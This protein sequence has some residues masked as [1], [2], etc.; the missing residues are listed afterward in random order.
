MYSYLI[1][2]DFHMLKVSRTVG[3]GPA[4]PAA[5][6]AIFDQLTRAKMEEST[7]CRLKKVPAEA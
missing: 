1:A 3:A 6:E 5:A 4:G 2:W 7:L